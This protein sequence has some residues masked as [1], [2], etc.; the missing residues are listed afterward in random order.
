MIKMVAS[1]M[2]GGALGTLGRFVLMGVVGQ[3]VSGTL[4]P[5]ATLAVNVVGCFI[6]GALV[7]ILALAW[8]PSPELRAFL[9]IGVLGGFT[10]FSAFSLDVFYLA[11]RGMMLWAAAYI[12]ASVFLSLVGYFIGQ[13]LFRLILA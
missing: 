2:V 7:E 1:V 9:I 8:S 13:S 4:L 5:V 6:M 12:A 11:D 10:T 3:W